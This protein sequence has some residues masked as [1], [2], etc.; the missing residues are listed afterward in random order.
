MTDPGP[1]T[2]VPTTPAQ[3]GRVSRRGAETASALN[4]LAGGWL[5]ASSWV[6]HDGPGDASWNPVAAGAV[7]VAVAA[8]RMARP[9]RSAR[10]AVANIVAGLWL[11]SSAWWLD[12]GP[13]ASWN[14]SVAGA[15]VATMAAWGLSASREAA[16]A[17]EETAR[18]QCG[19]WSS[20]EVL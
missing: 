11:L 8:V 12:P 3:A 2:P 10:L 16:T 5:V 1:P 15:V 4:L 13:T 17:E 18:W 20:G 19:T 14:V 7:I 9:S 6:L